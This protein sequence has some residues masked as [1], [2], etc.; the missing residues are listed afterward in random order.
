MQTKKKV[1]PRLGAC[2]SAGALLFG[3]VSPLA[4]A[5]AENQVPLD[6][7]NLP[8]R[9]P[10][11]PTTRILDVRN[12]AA[13][14]RFDVKAPAG[15]PNVVVV[16]IDDMG[17]GVSESFGGPVHMP[18]MNRLAQ[19]GLRYTRF[20]TTA[21]CAP[22]RTALLTGTAPFQQYGSHHGTRQHLSR[23]YGCASTDHHPS[24]RS[25]PAKTDTTR[26]SL[27]N[28]TKSRRGRSPTTGPGS[29]ADP[30]RIREI[31]RVPGRG[32]QPV[33]PPGL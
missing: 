12:A 5:N 18:T 27:A 32:N 30:I 15:A 21:L 19:N 3:N 31:L 1:S 8:I 29:L 6:R 13:P 24:G 20:H 7:S 2:V 33:G 16:L 11:Y 28:V 23:V 4:A 22:T 25:S 14:S 9:E 26:P 10:K 17:F